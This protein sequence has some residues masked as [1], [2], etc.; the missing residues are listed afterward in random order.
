MSIRVATTKDIKELSSVRMSVKENVLNNPALV[1][2]EICEEYITRRG[3][4]WV[5]E[6]DGA[7]VGFASADLRDKSVW[8]L[9]VRPEHEG[10]GIGKQLHDHMMDWYFAQTKETAWLTTSPHTRAEKFYTKAGWHNMGL[11]KNEIRFE[12]SIDDWNAHA[13]H[14]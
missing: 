14:F 3:K 1:T 11:H 10:R 7:I 6:L 8:A 13:T 5:Y 4:G 2:D 9:F 12:M